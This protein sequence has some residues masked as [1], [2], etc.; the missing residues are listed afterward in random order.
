MREIARIIDFRAERD[1][2]GS[3]P[4]PLFS[5]AENCGRRSH[6][7]GSRQTGFFLWSWKERGLPRVPGPGREG[8][9]PAVRL[10]G[11]CG[12][13]PRRLP[14]PCLQRPPP[15][16]CGTRRLLAGQPFRGDPTGSLSRWPDGRSAGP[17]S[18]CH[19]CPGSQAGRCHLHGALLS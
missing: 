4:H 9:Q 3:Q 10:G 6:L 2:G 12:G 14:C 16:S 17:G 5:R 11:C 1:L 19:S 18:P 13:L 7:S 15:A 8:G